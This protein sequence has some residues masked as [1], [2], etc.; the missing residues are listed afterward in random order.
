MFSERLK[1]VTSGENSCT[2]VGPEYQSLREILSPS[3]T[4]LA[5]NDDYVDKNHIKFTLLLRIEA[6][7]RPRRLH[8]LSL[9]YFLLFI[10]SFV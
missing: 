10:Y 7:H 4:N 5:K 9:V 6:V 2:S 8:Q 3:P 1:V